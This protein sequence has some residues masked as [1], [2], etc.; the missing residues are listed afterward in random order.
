M[1]K[2]ICQRCC[3]ER[4]VEWC[5]TDDTYWGFG[6]VACPVKELRHRVGTTFPRMVDGPPAW[7]FYPL[8]HIVMD[9]PC[10]T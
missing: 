3:R 4:G 1:K 8:E 9:Q 2:N 6:Y 5:H 10:C 7:C